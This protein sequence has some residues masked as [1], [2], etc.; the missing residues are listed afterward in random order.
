MLIL[1]PKIEFEVSVDAEITP[2]IALASEEEIANFEV[3]Y[4]KE[5]RKLSELFEVKKEGDSAKIVLEG[6]FSKV[7]WVGARM[8]EGEIVIRGNIGDHCGAYMTGGKI[9]VE[10]DALDWVGAE[11]KGGEIVIEGNARNYIGCAY[12]GDAT[13]M[14]GGKITIKG[15]ARNYIGEKMGGGEI[16]IHGDA[17]DFIGTE[18][19]D[20]LIVIH[21]NCG[22]VGGDMKGG[23]IKI[24]GNFE[25]VPGFKKTDDGFEGDVNVGGK[26]KVISF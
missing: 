13:G 8:D 6:D 2:S 15:N 23:T 18:M 22:F 16:E 12:W 11:M 1:K 4:G 26:G 7:K 24:K 17:E 19:K 10:G 5:K 3:F 14:S 9:I 25:L 20:G 21:G